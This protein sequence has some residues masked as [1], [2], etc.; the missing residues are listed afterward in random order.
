MPRAA[1][2]SGTSTPTCTPVFTFCSPS[3]K[4]HSHVMGEAEADVITIRVLHNTKH[5]TATHFPHNNTCNINTEVRR[6]TVSSTHN[7]STNARVSHAIRE[8]A[9]STNT[10]HENQTLAHQNTGT[11][12]TTSTQLRNA[13]AIYH[14]SKFLCSNSNHYKDQGAISRIR[15]HQ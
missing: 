4:D 9:S 8:A 5:S 14:T 12:I 3:E 1:A 2:L 6:S 7:V 13:S 10:V 11:V 15:R